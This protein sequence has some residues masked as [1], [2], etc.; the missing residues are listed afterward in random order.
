MKNVTFLLSA[1]LCCAFCISHAQVITKGSHHI[2]LGY[3][4]YSSFKTTS[5][6]KFWGPVIAGYRFALGKRITLGA[7]FGYGYG[8]MGTYSFQYQYASGPVSTL[9]DR[10]RYHTYSASLRFDYH[11]VN[12]KKMDI[13]SGVM[14]DGL[15]TYHKYEVYPSHNYSY[16]IASVG[17]CVAG[18]RYM[19]RP[20]VGVYGEFTYREMGYGVLG[21]STRLG[22]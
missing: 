14:L 17:L 15:Q 1:L 10:T 20:R 3:V 21:L 2:Y 22:K 4:P 7:E 8:D 13:Y 6:G 18:C 9:T 5:L 19:I 11:Y 12:G 16:G